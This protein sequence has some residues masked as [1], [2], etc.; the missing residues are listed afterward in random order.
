M[1]K[2]SFDEPLEQFLSEQVALNYFQLQDISMP[3]ALRV[4]TLP[5]HHR[6]P[7]DRMIVAQALVEGLPILSSDVALDAHGIT[8]LW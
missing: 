8:R 1:G 2:L 6:D 4:A 7:F 3:H 5:F